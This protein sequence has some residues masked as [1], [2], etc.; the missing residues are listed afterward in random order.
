MALDK[1]IL[2]L[3]AVKAG[4]EVTTSGGA[5][6]LA[7]DISTATREPLS[8]NTVKRL[9]GVLAYQGKPRDI[10]LQIIAKYLGYDSVSDL[11]LDIEGTPSDFNLPDSMI[12]AS[13]IP[14]GKEIYL[15]WRPNRKLIIR[16]LGKA[17]FEVTDSINSKLK[18]GDILM[19]THLGKGFPFRT[20]EV[21]REGQSLGP[22]TAAP[23]TGLDVCEI[24]GR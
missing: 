24:S 11:M 20:K 3:L 5:E 16:S 17:R 21:I 10:T 1:K 22:Y 9:T 23:E 12:D 19:L 7:R 18:R 13:V 8:V 6:K 14:S 4:Y 2:D 15:E